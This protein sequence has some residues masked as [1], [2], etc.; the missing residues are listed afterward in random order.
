MNKI[1]T[2]CQVGTFNKD[3]QTFVQ[4]KDTTIGTITQKSMIQLCN[5]ESV[6]CLTVHHIMQ[7]KEKL[8]NK[9]ISKLK[10]NLTALY[11]QLQ[12]VTKMPKQCHMLRISSN[13]L[14]LY[15]HPYFFVLYD[16]KVYTLVDKL[17]DRCRR[18][19]DTHNIIV[20]AHPDQ[21][22]VINSE[23]KDVRLKA[24]NTLYMHK[25][26]LERL[27]TPEKSCINIHL[28]GN[29]DHL[30]EID[31]GLFSDLIPWL[32]FENEDKNGKRFTGSVENTLEVCEK[33]NIRMLLDLHH[34]YAL[35]GDQISVNDSIV[36]RIVATWRGHTPIMHLSQGRDS[37]TDRKH[38]DFVTDI[39][40]IDYASN[41]LHLAHIEIEAKAKTSA[42]LGFYESVKTL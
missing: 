6:E 31:Q 21:Y 13:L 16:A 11:N 32:S 24:Y 22:C 39:D 35:T 36:D 40:L 25:Y 19:I 27:T 23:S 12:F 37:F 38:S 2:V 18:V 8:Q 7:N 30:P 41:F 9:L 20:C 33:Y 1:G 5:V 17:L 29:L 4:A 42:V 26:F 3:K 15:D 28:N 10:Q 14:P 34:H